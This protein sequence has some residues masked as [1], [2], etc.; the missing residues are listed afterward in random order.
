MAPL[1]TRQMC[2]GFRMQEERTFSQGVLEQA[3]NL[4]TV[5]R[6]Q[7]KK[8]GEEKEDESD[9]FMQPISPYT[10]EQGQDS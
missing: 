1:S 6:N 3:E 4:P 5:S 8:V 10:V 2:V 7:P 9:D